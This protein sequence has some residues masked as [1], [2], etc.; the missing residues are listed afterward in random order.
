[1]RGEW[2]PPLPDMPAP[3]AARAWARLTPPLG[4]EPQWR[5]LVE[6]A[7]EQQLSPDALAETGLGPPAG[8]PG[9]A[10]EPR[11][12]GRDRPGPAGCRPGVEAGHG[13]AVQQGGPLRR[14]GC[15]PTP[16]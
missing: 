3:P 11:R 8:R 6:A 5:R 14:R 2:Q 12:A 4:Y 1:M 7:L 9:A 16:D 10:A 15:R 13:R